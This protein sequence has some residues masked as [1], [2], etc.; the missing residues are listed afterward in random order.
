MSWVKLPRKLHFKSPQWGFWLVQTNAGYVWAGFVEEGFLEQALKGGHHFYW[1]RGGGYLL[2]W[3]WGKAAWTCPQPL[4]L[5]L[6]EGEW[7]N[8]ENSWEGIR[9]LA[10]LGKH[11]KIPPE[12]GSLSNCSAFSSWQAYGNDISHS[13]LTVRAQ[14][15]LITKNCWI[16]FT[17]VDLQR[18]FHACIKV[19]AAPQTVPK[20]QHQTV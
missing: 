3:K 16:E 19:L 14:K 5:L 8:A 18:S 6:W 17:S 9:E 2:H 4:P 10:C 7:K 12:T 1:R 20:S 13:H 15:C 11:L